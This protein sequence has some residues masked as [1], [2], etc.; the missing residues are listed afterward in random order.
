MHKKVSE[1]IYIRNLISIRNL[2][3]IELIS[4]RNRGLLAESRYSKYLI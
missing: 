4:I 1:L 2:Y 3:G